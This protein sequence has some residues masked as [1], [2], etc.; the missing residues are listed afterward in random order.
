[1]DDASD[2]DGNDEEYPELKGLTGKKRKQMKRKLK[3]KRY[4]QME[5][6]LYSQHEF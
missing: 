1:M 2:D 4:Q 6:E 5:K 3:K